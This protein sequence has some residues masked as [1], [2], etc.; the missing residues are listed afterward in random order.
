MTRVLPLTQ[1]K[2]KKLDVLILGVLRT[3]CEKSLKLFKEN[4]LYILPQDREGLLN[5]T[6]DRNLN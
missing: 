6:K 1:V 3:E 5:E 2:K 4:E